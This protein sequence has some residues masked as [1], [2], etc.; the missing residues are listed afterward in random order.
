MRLAQDQYQSTKTRI[1][2]KRLKYTDK[3]NKSYYYCQGLLTK[4]AIVSTNADK[5]DNLQFMNTNVI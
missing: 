3:T 2:L 4:Q 5:A 1:R